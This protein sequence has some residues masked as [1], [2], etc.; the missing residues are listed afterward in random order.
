VPAVARKNADTGL[1]GAVVA[2]ARRVVPTAPLLPP[3]GPRSATAQ[4]L[5]LVALELFATKGFAATSIRDIARAMDLQP[6]SL[7]THTPSKDHVLAELVLLGH[8]AHA[9]HIRDAIA[10][11]P[12]NPAAQLAAFVTAHVQVHTRWT[13]L[14]VV[15]NSELHALPAEL[16]APSLAVRQATSAVL[17]N[18][19]QRGERAG[20]FDVPD[21]M[22]VVA[23]I[24]AMGMRVATWFDSDGTH[25]EDDVA[26]VYTELALRMVKAA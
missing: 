19:I 3:T 1:A 2:G 18:I 23:A 25:D 7:Y 13:M 26:R 11:A 8:Q 24:A 17:Q 12:D 16:A 14:C 4:R 15:T 10:D 5:L 20:V 22:L 21:V 9:A 6:A